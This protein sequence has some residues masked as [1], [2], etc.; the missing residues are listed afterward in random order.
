MPSTPLPEKEP[1]TERE[2]H[3]LVKRRSNRKLQRVA[4]FVPHPTVVAGDYAEAVIAWR[5]IGVLDPELVDDRSPVQ[6]VALLPLI[7]KLFSVF[8]ELNLLCKSFA[9]S[10]LHTKCL[11]PSR[12]K[13]SIRVGYVER[14]VF[15]S[16]LAGEADIRFLPFQSVSELVFPPTQT[17]QGFQKFGGHSAFALR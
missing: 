9:G 6:V 5:Q 15:R 2:I 11:R 1:R 7:L 14:R 4:T 13:R 17:R 8:S 3:R 12:P 10:A 16:N